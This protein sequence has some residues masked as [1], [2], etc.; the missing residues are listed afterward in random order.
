VILP[1]NHILEATPA[2]APTGETRALLVHWGRLHLVRVAL[3]VAATL[4]ML[5]ALHRPT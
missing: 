4:V 3:G 1:T 5:V 2:D